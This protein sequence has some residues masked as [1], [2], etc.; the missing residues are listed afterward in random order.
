M[1]ISQPTPPAA[2]GRGQAGL[3]RALVLLLAAA[4]GVIVANNYYAQPLLPALQHAF[5]TSAGTAGLCVTLNQLGYAAGLVFIVPLGDLAG[6]R[7]LVTL[8]LALDAV[9]L[10]AAAAAPSA[11]ALIA[12][13]T[14]AGTAGTAINV[15]IPTA[16][17]LADDSQRGRVVGTLMTGL[18][19]GILLA[20]TVAGAI[21]SL[22]GWRPVYGVAA[23]AA[24][25]LALAL[26][27]KLPELPAAPGARY[28][29]LLASVVTLVRTQPFLRRRMAAGA[30]GFGAFQ[31]L[32]TALPFMLSDKPYAYAP[33]VIGL[34]GLLGAAGAAAAQP[35][36]RLQDRGIAHGATGVLLV[37]LAGSWALLAEGRNL[38]LLAAGIV[39]LDIGVQGVHV[40]NQGRIYLFP[41]QVRARATTAYMSAYFLGGAAGGAVAVALYPAWGWDGVCAAGAVMALA[42]LA[43]WAGDRRAGPAPAATTSLPRPADAAPAA[44]VGSGTG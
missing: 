24:A 34:F 4:C 16:A 41:A 42:G 28:P 15:L 21:D 18:L 3:P 17:S 12:L 14:A 2:G 10:A 20:R 32:W 27:A 35:A 43:L 11:W 30:L 31:L 33:A 25:A 39:L 1:S 40:L 44:G 38:L 5:G 19:L 26:H 7:R 37:L 13:L 29:Q 36:G 9:V 6:R 8:L 22:V 23:V